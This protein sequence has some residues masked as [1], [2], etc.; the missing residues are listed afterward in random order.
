MKKWLFLSSL[1]LLLLSS[2]ESETDVTYYVENRSSQTV[3][4]SGR[5]LIHSSDVSE[6]IA[7]SETVAF[8]NWSKLGKDATI[9]EPADVFSDLRIVNEGGDT[10]NTNFQ[11]LNQWEVNVEESRFM[12]IHQYTWVITDAD[13]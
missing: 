13:F 8:M 2:C 7:S 3:N 10:A 9:F 5:D 6:T 12:A 11:D 4:L 1:I